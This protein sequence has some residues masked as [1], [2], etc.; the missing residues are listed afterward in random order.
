[1]ARVI[2]FLVHVCKHAFSK[3][4]NKIFSQTNTDS[5]VAQEKDT[6]KIY[7]YCGRIVDQQKLISYNKI[8]IFQH[9]YNYKLIKLKKTLW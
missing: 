2:S 9:N 1:M 3:T 4:L 6:G 8:T 7:N 5:T